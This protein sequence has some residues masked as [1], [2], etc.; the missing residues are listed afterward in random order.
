MN[1]DPVES[2]GPPGPAPPPCSWLGDD[3]IALVRCRRG[4]SALGDRARATAATAGDD[5]MWHG[6]SARAHV[7]GRLIGHCLMDRST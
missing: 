1:D 4:D 7:V 6:M 5:D 2:I 3:Y